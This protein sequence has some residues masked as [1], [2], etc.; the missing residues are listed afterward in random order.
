MVVKKGIVP[1]DYSA[2][3]KPEVLELLFH[4]VRLP[5][6]PVPS[7]CDEHDI[8]VG[9]GVG[10]AARFHLPAEKD[11][12]NIIFFHGNGE[13]VGDY[14]EVGSLFAGQGL[15]FVVVDYR[16]Y[17]WSGGAPTV[18]S[19]LADSSTI[20][21]YVRAQL[22]GA[23]RA[24]HLVV[25]GRSLGSVSALELASCRDKELAGIIIESGFANTCPLLRSLGIDVEGLGITEATGFGNIPKIRAFMKPVLIL[26]AQNDQVIPLSEAAALHA[27]C[28]AAGKELQVIPGAGH[29]NILQ[30]TGR[31]YYEVISS[32]ARKLGRPVRRKKSGVR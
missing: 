7:G 27:E 11:G 19:M 2:L 4:P 31:L 16:G 3:D 9:P 25:M 6:T 15:G 13:L 28:G 17:G 23:G 14:D 30:V 21:D 8:P 24:G 29:N 26:H 18:S 22:A 1:R 32:F 12:P 5:R 10:V 20:F